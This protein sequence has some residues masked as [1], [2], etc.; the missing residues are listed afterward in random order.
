MAR[1]QQLPAEALLL[2]L[3]SPELGA[4]GEGAVLAGEAP[5]LA[6]LARRW[7]HGT[8]ACA[9]AHTYNPGA[10][11]A[12]TCAIA[13]ALSCAAVDLWM[14]GPVGSAAT[15]EQLA[16]IGAAVRLPLVP[17][18]LLAAAAVMMPAA[19]F[20]TWPLEQMRRYYR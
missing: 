18:P 12:S 14:A 17:G 19:A 15:P 2:L 7:W 13:I 16:T 1:L 10:A 5:V 8:C 11:C 4:W 3:L 6:T 20:A 9:A